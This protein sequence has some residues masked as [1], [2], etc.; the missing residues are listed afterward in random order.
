MR[1]CLRLPALLSA[2]TLLALPVVMSF[3]AMTAASA[4]AQESGSLAGTEMFSGDPTKQDDGTQVTAGRHENLHVKGHRKLPPGY[5]DAPSMDIEHGPDPEHAQHVV[6]D[7]VSGAALS[8][9]GS[10]YQDSGPT[11][12]GTLGDSTGNG[13]VAPR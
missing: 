13:W 8:K 6:R 12:T 10:A 2:A 4:A 1:A 3:D 5:Q 7:A 11:G 9:F